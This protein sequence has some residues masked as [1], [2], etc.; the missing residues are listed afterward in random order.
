MVAQI[1]VFTQNSIRITTGERKIYAD[2]FKINESPKDADFILIT[3]DHYDHFSPE[4][5]QKVAGKNTILI[6]P[7]KMAKKAE[8]VRDFVSRIV[9][10]EPGNSYEIDGLSFETVP[11]YN[12]IK[13]FHPKH[14]GYVG[15]ILVIDGERIYIAGDTDATKEAKAV[16][17]DI[18]LV[19]IGGTY[20]M[21]A[22]AAAELVN[23]ISPSVA[24][25]VHFGEIVGKPEDAKTF[26]S[27]VKES[28][29]VEEKIPF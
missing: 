27:L 7:E 22:K 28:V 26:A 11:A 3:H 10:V 12:S 5:I 9:P 15:Y 1:E 6:V 2:S 21:D 19:P 16:K 29:A 18:A 24:I 13:P 8:E 17:C 20:T 4:D 25:P 14:A 23:Q